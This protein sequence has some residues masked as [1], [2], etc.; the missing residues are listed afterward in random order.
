MIYSIKAVL[1]VQHSDSDSFPLGVQHSD[2]DTFPLWFITNCN[3]YSSL[4]CTVSL[5]GYLF[6]IQ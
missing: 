6:Y 1:G 4:H 5:V 3:E 2:S